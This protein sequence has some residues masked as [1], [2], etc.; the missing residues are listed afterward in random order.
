[1]GSGISTTKVTPM[2]AHL[3]ERKLAWGEIRDKTIKDIV[4]LNM[5]LGIPQSPNQ[6]DTH[7]SPHSG[8]Q[9]HGGRGPL[10]ETVLL[11]ILK[12]KLTQK[13]QPEEATIVDNGIS[14][15]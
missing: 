1:M 13:K 8:N 9:Y 11:E 7:P 15:V 12:T 3:N 10:E 2:K 14:S 5:M 4:P 6:S